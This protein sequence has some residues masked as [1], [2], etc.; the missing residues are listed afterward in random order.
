ME[1]KILKKDLKRKKSM[2]IILLV[3]VMLATTFIAASL[4]NLRIVTNGVQEYFEKAGVADFIIVALNGTGEGDPND[5]K[6]LQFLEEDS[7]VEKYYVDNSFIMLEGQMKS[8]YDIEG[9][10]QSTII[11][12]SFDVGHQKFFDINNN[13]ITQM[14]EGTIYFPQKMVADSDIEIGDSIFFEAGSYKKEFKYAGVVKDAFMGPNMMGQNR[15]VVSPEDFKEMQESKEFTAETFYAVFGDDIEG[16][17][18]EYNNL[19]INIVFSADQKLMFSTYSMD[20]VIAAVFLGISLCLIL[21]AAIMLRFTIVF[22]ISEDYREIGIMK[23]IGVPDFTIRKLYLAKYFVL[24]I[25]GAAWGFVA[26]IPFGRLMLANVTDL[27]VIDVGDNAF[28]LQMLVSVAVAFMVMFSAYISTGKIKSFTPLDA[29]RSGNN[30]E[31]FERKTVFR[32]AKSKVSATTFMAFNDVLCELK[33]YMILL[34]ASAIG[35]WLVVMPVNTINTLRSKEIAAWFGM[36]DCDFYIVEQGKVETLVSSADKQ[37]YYDYVEETKTQLEEV[38]VPVDTVW[39]EVLL[40]LKVRKGENS[41][42][43]MAMQGLG[44]ETD[45][46]MYETGEPPVYENEVA[47]THIVAE[48]L[49]AVV[50]DTV[51]INTGDE[52]K[53]YVVTAIYQ[54]MNNMG[55]GIRFS[56]ETEIDYKKQMGG[57]GLQVRLEEEPTDEELKDIIKKA[58]KALPDATMETTTEFVDSMMG[59]IP[60]Q[61]EPMKLLSLVIV[62]IVNILVVVLMQKMFLIREQEEMGM[63]KAIG[64]SN[65]AIISWQTK[66]IMLVLFIGIL[67]GTI[68]GTPFSQITSGK[69]FQYMGA[70]RIA[71]QINPF[72]VYFLY[73]VVLFVTIVL[74][75]ILTM[76]KVRKISLQDMRDMD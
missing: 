58:E 71:F 7:H 65:G 48:Q 10:G 62:L 18:K 53:P 34:A 3:F 5:E 52:E 26:S 45:W 2:N 76:Q 15:I 4:N 37:L 28:L 57:F 36:A 56:E 60:D 11:V 63:L 47:I 23:A 33:K 59:S 55:E 46:Y 61:L 12:S 74:S 43:S 39:T 40:R 17:K 25:L 67:L 68:T 50:G 66:R 44:S 41:Y 51:Y 16:F 9:D 13:E 8:D 69:V 24:T 49:D 72:E 73:P 70:S 22:T 64:F 27:I 30:G 54:S 38:G 32:L 14:E 29:I 75:C 1:L 20:M 19:D 31:R 21:I 35:V 6:I 42:I